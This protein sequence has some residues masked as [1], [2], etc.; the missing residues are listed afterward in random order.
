MTRGCLKKELRSNSTWKWFKSLS[1]APSSE[2]QKYLLKWGK[3][4]AFQDVIEWVT[5]GGFRLSEIL[6]LSTDSHTF[7]PVFVCVPLILAYLP[8]L[9]WWGK[10]NLT[11]S[12]TDPCGIGLKLTKGVT[13]VLFSGRLNNTSVGVCVYLSCLTPPHFTKL[14]S[15]G[16]SILVK[17]KVEHKFFLLSC[18]CVS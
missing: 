6:S 7:A 18:P 14:L 5:W 13:R 3:S 4:E 16:G 1:S 8:Q 9:L 15:E 2:L 11:E 17:V 12:T 10:P